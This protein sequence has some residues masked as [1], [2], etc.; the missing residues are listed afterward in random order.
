MGQSIGSMLADLGALRSQ[1][2]PTSLGA[3]PGRSSA[4]SS[5]DSFAAQLDASFRARAE[6]LGL[7]LPAAA[8]GPSVPSNGVEGEDVNAIWQRAQLQSAALNGPG[9]AMMQAVGEAADARW[10]QRQRQR[11]GGGN[12]LFDV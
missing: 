12:G 1:Q 6:R 4:A 8:I 11:H 5:S 2:A 9:D 10:E 3:I 7:E